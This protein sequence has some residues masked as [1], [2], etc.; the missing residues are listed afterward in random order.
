[1]N[2]VT[3]D[4]VA[5]QLN[6]LHASIERKLKSTVTDAIEAGRLL[7][8]KKAELPHGEFL[9]W[10]KENCAFSE[11]TA[12]NYTRLFRYRDKT[13]RVADLQEAY[14]QVEQIESRKQQLERT[15]AM[16]RVKDYLKTGEKPDGWRRG[17]DDK[18]AEEERERRERAHREA[19][20]LRQEMQEKETERHRKKEDEK[21]ERV[22]DRFFAE[23]IEQIGQREEKRA[24][25]KE[26]I[27]LSD[28][29]RDDAFVDAIMD[30]LEELENDSRRIE[31]C[32]NIIKV[33][34]NVAADLQR[35]DREEVLQ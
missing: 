35:V 6:E 20:R 24:S 3:T 25:F 19:E 4:A 17:T 21:R 9:P 8:E 15:N 22:T 32:Q 18:L 10:L 30:Y 34:R 27:R 13:A 26:R 1:M 5:K 14:R 33:C 23:A 2:E 31:A 29:G 12:Q 16:H 11:R 28:A 7:S